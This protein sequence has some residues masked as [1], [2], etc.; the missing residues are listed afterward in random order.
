MSGD[1]SP[2]AA[3]LWGLAG[4]IAIEHPE[5]RVRIVDLDP[6]QA[7]DDPAR[8]IP[9]ASHGSDARVAFRDR[10]AMGASIASLFR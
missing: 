4:V 1:P 3:G 9:R 7:L 5:L 2:R 8:S 10:R 6:R